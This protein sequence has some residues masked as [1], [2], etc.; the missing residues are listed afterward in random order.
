MSENNKIENPELEEVLEEEIGEEID[1]SS[2]ATMNPSD[3][4]VIVDLVK[5]MQ[6]QYQ[7]LKEFSQTRIKADYGLKPEILQDIISLTKED[8]N[9]KLDEILKK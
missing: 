3:Y 4:K 5:E 7:T 9:K 6:S 1:D 2:D 8:I